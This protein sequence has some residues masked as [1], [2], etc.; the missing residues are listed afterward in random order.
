M[1]RN[2][3]EILKHALSPAEEPDERLNRKILYQAEEITHMAKRRNRI[4]AAVLA[5]SFTLIVGSTAVF[6]A[7]KYLSPVQMAEEFSESGLADAF[8]SEDAL[9]VNE[10]QECGGYRVTLLGTVSGENFNNSVHNGQAVD[11]MFY[12]AVAIERADGTAMPD[13]SDDAYGEEAFFVSPYIKGL[14]P[15][16]YNAITIGGGYSE[17]VQDGIQYRMLEV[18]GI[19]MFADRGIYLGVNSGSF[20]DNSAFRFDRNTGEI[21]RNEFYDGVNA[22]F[23]L[24]IDPAKA[25]PE[26]AEALLKKI[27]NP[28]EEEPFEQTAAD[29]EVDEWI[30]QITAENLDDYAEIIESTV[31]TCKPNEAGEFY[32][33]WEIGEDGPGGNGIGYMDISFPDR[34]PGTRVI[35]GYS[36]DEN[37]LENLYIETH[38]L[39]EDGTVTV[40]IY[41]PKTE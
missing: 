28:V 29:M 24:P 7:W 31:Q 26:A 16:Q 12:A 33:S 6:A 5:A 40:A 34:K 18:G 11:G 41:K 14:D 15:V 4:P 10:T 13:T 20:P 37:G 22:L 23:V 39:N 1:K 2:M 8:Q 32:Y 36:Y 35:N 38:T 19:E 27:D 21:T 3:D 30:A 25:D 17:F 9:L